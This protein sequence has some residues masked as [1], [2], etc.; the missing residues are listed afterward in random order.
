MLELLI[1]LVCFIGGA[2][3]LTTKMGFD[4]ELLQGLLAGFFFF[5][6][7]DSLTK[8]IVAAIAM[9]GGAIAGGLI[10]L[11]INLFFAYYCAKKG[12]LI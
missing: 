4:N 9:N 11:A 10:M 7:M 3:F 5:T 12:N 6:G 2:I 8:V 1:G